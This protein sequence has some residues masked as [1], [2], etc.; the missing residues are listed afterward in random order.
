MTK[1]PIQTAIDALDVIARNPFLMGLLRDTKHRMEIRKALEQLRAHQ[2]AQG[3]QPIETAPDTTKADENK[4]TFVPIE[5]H[6][7]VLLSGECINESWVVRGR[8]FYS[9]EE[10]RQHAATIKA[11]GGE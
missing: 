8:V 10:A 4:I 6:G 7:T 1:D 5:H 11:A 2:S 9:L 3:R